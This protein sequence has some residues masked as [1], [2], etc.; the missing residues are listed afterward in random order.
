MNTFKRKSVSAAVLAGLGAVGVAGTAE[1]VHINS[2]GMGEVLLYPYYTVRSPKGSNAS[3][4]KFDTYVAVTN[5]TDQVKAV[6]LRFL[7]GRRSAEVLDF[8]LFLSPF[9]MWTG[10]ILRTSNGAM[11]VS[12][13]TSCVL[14]NNLFAVKDPTDALAQIQGTPNV[15]K[16]YQYQTAN[17]GDVFGLDRVRE[18]HFEMIEM[19][20]ITRAVDV[21]AATHVNGVPGN[22][23]HFELTETSP[24]AFVA[25]TAALLPPEG[26]LFG[27]A[28]LVNP[29]SGTNFTYDAVALD[30][31]SDVVNYS[32]TGATSPAITDASP[33]T[34][35]VFTNAG[36]VTADWTN[37]EEAV[38][39]TLMHSSLA[40]EYVL[41]T[42]TA[43]GTD[44]VITFPTKSGHVLTGTNTTSP[45]DINTPPNFTG[46]QG[47]GPFLNQYDDGSCEIYQFSI[48]DR[49]ERS[50]G[51][52]TVILPS[53]LPNEVPISSALCW[54]TNV[55]SYAGTR[56]SGGA[57][58][59]SNLLGSTLGTQAFN[60]NIQTGFANVQNGWAQMS[61]IQPTQR[62][63]PVAMTATLSTGASGVNPIDLMTG[64]HRGLPVIGFMVHDYINTN[65][66]G[67]SYGG[68]VAHKYGRNI[69]N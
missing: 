26:G 48:W 39:A 49:E 69:E 67:S 21:T 18:G 11:L 36:L 56:Q 15:F 33:A 34:S 6:K 12:N 31:W 38:S 53:P 37:P 14:P 22:C 45:V 19:A 16:N 13:D 35:R 68:V 44:W 60:V 43:S 42:A 41:D 59:T 61:F 2:D 29:L 3:A 51:V 57:P 52:V 32:S 20:V 23:K 65:V 25:F 9:D 55:L 28:S 4:N 30:D 10:A 62:I 66:A 40:N 27:R 24:A 17:D 7:E 46:A 63:I 8:N 54:E 64:T 47:T 50:P 58:F 5:T 1:A